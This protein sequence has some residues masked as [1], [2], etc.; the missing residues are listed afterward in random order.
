MN[1]LDLALTDQGCDRCR[2]N[3]VTFLSWIVS[4]VKPSWKL[5]ALV[6]QQAHSYSGVGV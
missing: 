6:L 2:L 1:G 5:G 3:I 4:L